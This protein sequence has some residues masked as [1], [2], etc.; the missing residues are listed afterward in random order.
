MIHSRHHCRSHFQWECVSLCSHWRRLCGHL[1]TQL[2]A[3]QA[4]GAVPHSSS[5][6][7]AYT[8][9]LRIAGCCMD[10]SGR[11]QL[12]RCRVSLQQRKSQQ[13]LRQRWVRGSSGAYCRAWSWIRGLNHDTD[14]YCLHALAVPCR[15]QVDVTSKTEGK[16]DNSHMLVKYDARL[17]DNV[18]VNVVQEVTDTVQV[19]G[20]C[21]GRGW[22]GGQVAPWVAVA[23]FRP[24]VDCTT[25]C[26]C[27][28][29]VVQCV[30]HM[31]WVRY[32]EF[33]VSLSKGPTC[34]HFVHT[35]VR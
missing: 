13:Q 30:A 7:G 8:A 16:V 1:Y 11:Q 32:M 31:H 10:G 29:Q 27:R 25:W 15:P 17:R 14:E 5:S 6:G 21:I 9:A 22:A 4:D 34:M 19:R 28:L 24:S 33:W 20:A 26:D 35:C 23:L 3:S 18:A 2:T 12:A